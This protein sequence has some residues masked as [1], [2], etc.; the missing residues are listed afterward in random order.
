MRYITKCKSFWLNDDADINHADIASSVSL[1]LN[2]LPH[3]PDFLRTW[4]EGF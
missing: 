2:P 1:L 3:N 4:K